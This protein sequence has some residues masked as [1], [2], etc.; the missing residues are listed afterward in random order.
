M[1]ACTDSGNIRIVSEK[2][3]S[4][5][6]GKIHDMSVDIP[7]SQRIQWAKET[8]QGFVYTFIEIH[9][10][11]YSNFIIFSICWLHRSEPPI[12]HRDLKPANVLVSKSLF[13]F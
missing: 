7:L 5:L 4:D 8:C 12:V 6:D 9:R 10:M 11:G 13:S 3:A 1:G 2:L